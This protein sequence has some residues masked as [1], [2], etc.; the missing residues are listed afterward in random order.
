MPPLYRALAI[1][2]LVG[3]LVGV[4]L[5]A[6]AR[7]EGDTIR[8]HTVEIQPG[9]GDTVLYDGRHYGGSI[10]VSGHGSGIAVVEQVSIDGYLSGIQEVPFSWDMAALQAQAIAARTYLAW[11]LSRGRTDTGAR[12]GYDICATS[13]CQVYAGYEPRLTDSG[14]RWLEAVQSTTDQI[15]VYDGAPAATYYSSTTGGRTRTASDIWADVDL[16][17]LQAVDSP[18]ED[19]P[20]AN[21]SWRLPQQAMEKVLREAGLVEGDLRSIVTHVADDGQGPWTIDIASTRANETL[22]T[23]DLRSYLNR[24]GPSA[25]GGV[26]PAL[27]PDGNRYPQV[28]LSPSYTISSVGI[29]L[30]GIAGV[31]ATSI[32]QVSGHGW[33]HLVGMSQYG[34]QA[35]AEQGAG[36]DQILAHY[37]GGLTPSRRP[38]L[39][40]STVEV[41]LSTG[42]DEVGFAVTG[43]TSVLIDGEEVATDELGS[44]SFA[45][46]AGSVVVTAPAGL[47]LPP[48]LRP[49]L[50]GL[51]NGHLVLRIELTAAARVQWTLEVGG[52]QVA[53]YGPSNQDA[54][55]ISI[56][57]PLRGGKVHMEVRASN[58]HGGDGLIFDF[59][60]DSG[61][62]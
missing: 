52:E 3:V 9:S 61:A 1:G 48:R 50:I 25:L 31:T 59:P 26:L 58:R 47:G 38:D 27:R 60:I 34:A 20:F 30:P 13:A 19:S 16:P 36:A 55:F 12:L 17:Y 42:A 53:E 56:P 4:P 24:A 39:L 33:G 57:I 5:S 15:L 22:S 45:A 62:R 6:S 11:T 28:I 40:P 41:A 37:Y 54:G 44:W 21:W 29:P 43:P 32:Y 35:M 46:D 23:W 49:G 7:Q 14:R 18:G 10:R 8:A 2:A 51:E